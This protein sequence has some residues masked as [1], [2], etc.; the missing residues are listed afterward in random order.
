LAFANHYFAYAYIA[1]SVN[2][3][4]YRIWREVVARFKSRFPA[5]MACLQCMKLPAE[6]QKKI[7]TTNLLERLFKE[8]RRRIKVMPHF[9]AEKAGMKLVYATLLA[10]SQKWRGGRMDPFIQ[11]QIDEVW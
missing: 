7:R 5:A 4:M 9:F 6:H 8:N 11:K 10:T 2:C 3:R 1:G